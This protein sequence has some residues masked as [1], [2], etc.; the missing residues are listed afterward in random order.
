MLRLEEVSL[1]SLN[2][3]STACHYLV[4]DKVDGDWWTVHYRHDFRQLVAHDGYCSHI[5]DAKKDGDRLFR[6]PDFPSDRDEFA[7]YVF[8][9][10]RKAVDRMEKRD[11]NVSSA[12]VPFKNLNYAHLA[13][14]DRVM[15]DFADV[16]YPITPR[17]CVVC[18]VTTE[19]VTV[20]YHGWEKMTLTLARKDW[21]WDEERQMNVRGGK[22]SPAEIRAEHN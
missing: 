14:G 9:A 19:H 12:Q 4:Y 13:I 15:L 22:H 1:D 10:A 17:E 5:D 11:T 7:E 3:E 6:L 16:K 2:E 18:H 8:T 20:D 21:S